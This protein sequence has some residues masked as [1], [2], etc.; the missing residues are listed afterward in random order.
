MYRLAMPGKLSHFVTFDEPQ[1]DAG[2]GDPY[3]KASIW[4]RYLKSQAPP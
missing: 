4:G 2:G 3:R 1:P